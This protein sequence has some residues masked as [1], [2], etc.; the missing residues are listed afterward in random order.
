MRSKNET[1]ESVYWGTRN[2]ARGSRMN[3][4]MVLLYGV[5]FLFLLL[6]GL[7]RADATRKVVEPEI[8][9]SDQRLLQTAAEMGETNV[10][11][12]ASALDT[13]EDRS[14]AI[15]FMAGNYYFQGEAYAD[16]IVA[17]NEAIEKFP[18]FRAAKSNLGRIYLLQDEPENM[19]PLYQAL[20][21]SGQ[22]DAEVY[23]LLGHAMHMKKRPVS[24]ETA[25][26]HALLLEPQKV[27]ALS[28]L[29]QALLE[30]ER[31]QEALALT[32]E[33]L[34]FTPDKADLWQLRANAKMMLSQY[35]E[36]IHTIEAAKR[37]QL[38]DAD[39]L[40][41]QGDLLLHADQPE[42]ALVAYLTAFEES[43]PP[44]ERALRALEG[45]LMLEDADG[46]NQLLEAVDTA[47]WPSDKQGTLYR[48]RAQQ[49]LLLGERDRAESLAKDAV[50]VNPMDGRALLLLA[51][52][53][54]EAEQWDRAVM[55]CER[56]ARIPDYTVDA[57]VLQAEI[58][59][60]RDRLDEAIELL[61]SAQARRDQPH[62]ARYLEQLRRMR[63]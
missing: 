21:K 8:S 44:P 37:L 63:R 31:Y 39:L 16:A 7:C 22:A 27:E 40:S 6:P 48:Y 54:K 19:I 42:D 15:A 26:R 55:Y 2:G 52:I 62:V 36:A 56:A 51:S 58:A 24:A 4:I 38:A 47:D 45:F 10:L 41:L 3:M 12:A 61:E 43:E 14:A 34:A 9:S 53:A 25:F 20:V 5:V 33:I 28:G 50:Q 32:T 29:A 30:Q 23:M 35:D 49:A 57:W 11:A 13:G 17:Y 60:N 59:V 18:G 46:M 1:I